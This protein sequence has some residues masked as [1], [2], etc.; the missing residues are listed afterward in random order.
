MAKLANLKSKALTA[1]RQ[2][3]KV[4]DIEN[5]GC[6]DERFFVHLTENWSYTWDPCQVTHSR[7]FTRATDAAKAVRDAVPAS[8]WPVRS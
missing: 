4:A 3:S 7:S 6:D 1:L 2:N 8:Q 5:E